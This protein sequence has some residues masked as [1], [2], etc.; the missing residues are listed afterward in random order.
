MYAKV[1]EELLTSQKVNDV[2]KQLTEGAECVEIPE[3]VIEFETEVLLN[4]YKSMASQYGMEF[5]DYLTAIGVASEEAFIEQS[6]D[7]I[8]AN[9][10][11]TLAIQAFLDA[12]GIEV[13]DADLD[14][15]FEGEYDD[16]IE[17][18][19]KPYLKLAIMQDIAMERLMENMK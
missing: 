1:T 18:Y 2:W 17:F 13:T 10:A 3:T 8:K 4:Y 11:T 5:A 9:A 19:G 15:Y 12:E 6:M 7:Q 16:L 14:E